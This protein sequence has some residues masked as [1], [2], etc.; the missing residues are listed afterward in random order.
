MFSYFHS[1]KSS[2]FPPKCACQPISGVRIGFGENSVLAGLSTNAIHITMYLKLFIENLENIKALQGNILYELFSFLAF[3][4]MWLLHFAEFVAKLSAQLTQGHS[5]QNCR[6]TW[7][8][9]GQFSIAHKT[10]LNSGSLKV[11]SEQT[12]RILLVNW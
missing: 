10:W 6:A 7:D 4:V 9:S 5:Q 8:C 3:P 1:Q 12:F 11:N 2:E